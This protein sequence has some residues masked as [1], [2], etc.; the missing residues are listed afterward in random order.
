M[1]IGEQQAISRL[2]LDQVAGQGQE[3]PAVSQGVG[4]VVPRGDL[5]A[6]RIEPVERAAQVMDGQGVVRRRSPSSGQTG[7]ARVRGG[8]GLAD[9]GNDHDDRRDAGGPAF[10][11]QRTE[12]LVIQ[13][14]VV[15][16]A[17]LP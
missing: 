5:E 8:I 9:P 12:R 6:R 14:P 15:R 7:S 16:A 10:R 11:G 2:V 1:R 4:M 13:L 17:A 3:E